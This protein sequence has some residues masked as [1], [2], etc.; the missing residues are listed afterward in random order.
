MNDEDNNHKVA[1]NNEDVEEDDDLEL[2]QAEI[3]RMEQEAAKLTKETEELAEKQ[4][5]KNSGDVAA[6]D[7]PAR[8]AYVCVFVFG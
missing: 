1:N 6:G 4:Q 8:D 3:A 2:L 7:K 5:H